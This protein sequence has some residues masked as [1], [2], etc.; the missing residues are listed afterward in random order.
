MSKEN[1]Q[2]ETE[3]SPRVPKAVDSLD[4]IVRGL[5]FPSP[6]ERWV[7]REWWEYEQEKNAMR[8]A[9]IAEIFQLLGLPDGDM[10]AMENYVTARCLA[11][12]MAKA[13]ELDASSNDIAEAMDEAVNEYRRLCPANDKIL[14]Q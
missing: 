13:W 6:L 10:G 4:G 14:P 8:K 5:P 11:E 2:A 9:W 3:A 1:P 7:R 12:K